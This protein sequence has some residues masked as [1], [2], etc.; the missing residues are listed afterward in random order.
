MAE[1]KLVPVLVNL[2]DE[3]LKILLERLLVEVGGTVVS[4]DNPRLVFMDEGKNARKRGCE[5]RAKAAQVA[6]VIDAS[7]ADGRRVAEVVKA[8]GMIDYV[9]PVADDPIV[10][11]GV[12]STLSLIFDSL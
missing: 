5:S 10:L 11:N 4:R 9:I 3:R 1:S 2:Y 12:K 7:N 8:V 6:W